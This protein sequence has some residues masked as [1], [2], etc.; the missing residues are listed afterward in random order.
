MSWDGRVTGVPFCGLSMLCEDNMSTWASRIDAWL[1]GTWTA[2]WS[3]S[4]SALKAPQTSGWS[5]IAFP[6]MRRGWK[7]WIESRCSVGARFSSTGCPFRIFSRISQ[8]TGSL[9]STSFLA[10]LTV[11][12]I[13]RSMSLRITKG[14]NSSAAIDLGIPHSWSFRV[15]PTTMTERP[16]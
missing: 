14:L 16:E 2:I 13:P 11:L 4:K 1:S 7:A 5:W 15:G 3:P 10:D 6:S 12:T 8:M 9:R